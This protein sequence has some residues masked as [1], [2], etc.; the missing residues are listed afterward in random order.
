MGQGK[1]TKEEQSKNGSQRQ[2]EIQEI[3]EF[4]EETQ[5]VEATNEN[6]PEEQKVYLGIT[7]E[8]STPPEAPTPPDATDL[9][10]NKKSFLNFGRNKKKKKPIVQIEGEPVAYF[11]NW[12]NQQQQ[13]TKIPIKLFED[14]QVVSSCEVIDH[15]DF[16]FI[17]IRRKLTFK[18][19]KTALIS[20]SGYVKRDEFTNAED[21]PPYNRRIHPVY[22]DPHKLVRPAG[23]PHPNQKYKE[24]NREWYLGLAILMDAY[25]SLEQAEEEGDEEAKQTRRDIA[26]AA[27]Q[28]YSKVATFTAPDT[29]AVHDKKEKN[30]QFHSDYRGKQ[31]TAFFNGGGYYRSDG[32]N[33]INDSVEELLRAELGVNNNIVI[34]S[35]SL[36]LET[37]KR[38]FPLLYTIKTDDNVGI[39]AINIDSIQT[40][41]EL[42]SNFFD[43]IMRGITVAN[44]FVI[45]ISNYYTSLQEAKEAPIN[46]S[47][48]V[49]EVQNNLAEVL[50]RIVKEK[51][52]SQL[53][54]ETLLESCLSKMYIAGLIA[55]AGYYYAVEFVL[56]EA[57][58]NN[59]GFEAV[60]P[61]Q[62]T[63][64]QQKNNPPVRKIKD[65]TEKKKTKKKLKTK[66][67][68]T[69]IH[70]IPNR[71]KE[72]DSDV[73][74]DDLLGEYPLIYTERE[75]TIASSEETKIGSVAN[76]TAFVINFC[77]QLQVGKIVEK[78]FVLDISPYY[79]AQVKEKDEETTLQD[80]ITKIQ[81]ELS[82][83]L[84]TT[85][86]EVIEIDTETDTEANTRNVLIKKCLEK[87]NIFAI[88]VHEGVH[89]YLE[90]DLVTPLQSKDEFEAETLN[91]KNFKST[92]KSTLGSAGTK[93]D[94]MSAKEANLKFSSFENVL[95]AQGI[96]PVTLAEGFEGNELVQILEMFKAKNGTKEANTKAKINTK[97]VNLYNSLTAFVSSTIFQKF[98]ALSDN[99]DHPPYVQ[100]YSN[101]TAD[102]IE[103]LTK[104]PIGETIDQVFER[105]RIS[106]LLKMTYVRMHLGILSAMVSINNMDSFINAIELLH[107]YIQMILAI[108][109]PYRQDIDFHNAML[110]AHTK[111]PI[112]GLDYDILENQERKPKQEEAIVKTVAPTIAP[113]KTNHKSTMSRL[114]NM[115]GLKK[116]KG[117]KKAIE[118]PIKEEKVAP[119]KSVKA[120]EVSPNIYEE[121]H[122]MIHH[123]PSYMHSFSSTLSGVE[124]QKG[125]NVLNI[126]ILKD[127]YYETVGSKGY[128]GLVQKSKA[129]KSYTWDGKRKVPE[130]EEKFDIYAC[131]FHHNI[132][133]TRKEY[134]TENLIAQ[135]NQLYAE[136]KVADKFTVSIDC[137]IDYVRS[138]EVYDFLVSQKERIQSGALNVV[139]NRSSQ[140]FDMLGLDNYYG[141]FSVT[142][143]NQD[144]YQEFNERILKQEGH[145][146]GLTHQGLTHVAT[147]GSHHQERYRQA[148]M[149]STNRFYN[150]LA[151]AGLHEKSTIKE[152]I[153][154]AKNSDPNAVFIDIRTDQIDPEN[155]QS[156]RYML[157]IKKWAEN[158]NK[159]LGQRAS[160]GFPYTNISFIPGPGGRVRINPGLESEREIDEY[161]NFLIVLRELIDEDASYA[162]RGDDKFLEFVNDKINER[163]KQ[164]KKTLNDLPANFEL[165]LHLLNDFQKGFLASEVMNLTSKKIKIAAYDYRQIIGKAINENDDETLRQFVIK[166]T[167]NTFTIVSKGQRKNELRILQAQKNTTN[168]SKSTV[169]DFFKQKMPE[170]LQP[171]KGK[172]VNSIVHLMRNHIAESKPTKEAPK[173]SY[174]TE[175]QRKMNKEAIA[176]MLNNENINEAPKEK[177]QDAESPW[178]FE[179]NKGKGD[180][181]FYALG[182]TNSAPAAFKLRQDIVSYQEAQGLIKHGYVDNQIGRMLRSS[183]SQGLRNLAR[184]VDGREGIPVAAYYLLMRQEGI[185][186]GL[187]EIKAFSAMKDQT[188][189]LVQDN[190]RINRINGATVTRTD[191][192]PDTA[193]E[194]ENLVLHQSA[195]HFKI[196]IA[197]REK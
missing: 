142:I 179:D 41:E 121:F 34:V 61:E 75:N 56:N 126:L 31:G 188:I 153:Y 69:D 108:V 195:S 23:N 172:T 169:I 1:N 119:K 47:A 182:R 36:A 187:E 191:T 186:G 99:K 107:N 149:R 174:E 22:I 134:A 157:R 44:Q 89:F 171:K 15:P 55:D 50:T 5:E 78:D 87:L 130:S 92:I 132:S 66:K 71:K 35:D 197:R 81:G 25:R 120:E 181:L 105:K 79:K 163:T 173:A 162:T 135:V 10:G 140:K 118:K 138:K 125:S 45:D 194:P 144:D 133:A 192:L 38:A 96:S 116:K 37:A 112:E 49:I 97:N 175:S 26:L 18:D 16:S 9:L 193:F 39:E 141:G 145:A 100:I 70:E 88:D 27:L 128:A 165:P 57:V 124:L 13:F 19:G 106:G 167:L 73:T 196:I 24:G 29:L 183:N 59:K 95:A 91:V 76:F 48:L 82:E 74:M 146:T 178:L 58:R 67:G 152:N 30:K 113:K 129:Y 20:K 103:G 139:L 98:R 164:E 12:N 21:W 111:S 28:N 101:A 90:F 77:T 160:F 148:L 104:L 158:H 155:K 122:T 170:K 86:Y 68:I 14:D 33:P 150:K 136:E 40:F 123:Q 4:E 83:A 185:W 127:N 8:A 110:A 143:N 184:D 168:T 189:Y 84:F 109:K 60:L 102:L 62:I 42:I 51:T 3:N 117:T 115:A 159:G 190:G 94:P 11:Y 156:N 151:A 137:T 32:T 63:P 166:R 161:A 147:H 114:L 46:H 53:E 64:V 6:T 54:Q 176:R 7:Q 180:C 17:R 43:Q 80:V 2:P 154:I 72:V 131:D 65:P 177:I 52:T 93:I 85:I